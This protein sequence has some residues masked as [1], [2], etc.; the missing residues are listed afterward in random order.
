ME[1]VSK[2]K[3]KHNHIPARHPTTTQQKRR[4]PTLICLPVCMCIFALTHTGISVSITTQAYAA[5]P[6]PLQD[7]YT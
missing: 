2:T 4:C 3:K 5:D 7:P 6:D 1:L